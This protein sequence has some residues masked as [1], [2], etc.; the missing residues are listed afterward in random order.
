MLLALTLALSPAHA[1]GFG[2]PPTGCGPFVCRAGVLNTLPSLPTLTQLTTDL[3]TYVGAGYDADTA[4]RM[5]LSNYGAT[6]FASFYAE[7]PYGDGTQWVVYSVGSLDVSGG[8]YMMRYEDEGDW[9]S[10]SVGD[11]TIDA[12]GQIAANGGFYY[13]HNGALYSTRPSLTFIWV[14][15]DPTLDGDSVEYTLTKEMERVGTYYFSFLG[16]AQH[17]WYTP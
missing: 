2:D 13:V 12:N 17:V 7:G 6:D 9:K 1:S 14:G 16:P 15:G 4:T 11:V 3:A 8:A 10:I 5:V